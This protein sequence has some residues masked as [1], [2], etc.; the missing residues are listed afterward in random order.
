MDR[1]SPALVSPYPGLVVVRTGPASHAERVGVSDRLLLPGAPKKTPCVRSRHL[2]FR[3][4]KT[5]PSAEAS[6]RAPRRLGAPSDLPTMPGVP[7][8]GRG[9]REPDRLP[10]RR[11]LALPSGEPQPRLVLPSNVHEFLL[12]GR[13]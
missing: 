5:R 1:C 4:S 11:R 12:E 7:G 13:R 10:G 9:S 6:T 8:R 2:R 3:R